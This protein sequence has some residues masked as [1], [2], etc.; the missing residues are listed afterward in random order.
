MGCEKTLTKR[1]RGIVREQ[2]KVVSEGIWDIAWVQ[3]NIGR[4]VVDI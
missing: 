3:D 4:F 2:A 1:G